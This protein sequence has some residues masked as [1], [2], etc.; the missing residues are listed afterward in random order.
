MTSPEI[1]DDHRER[2]EKLRAELAAA[3]A[4]AYATVETDDVLTYLLDLADAVDDPGRSADPEPPVDPEPPTDPEPPADPEPPFDREAVRDRLAERNRQHADPEDADR[5]DLY[6]I[7]AEFDVAGRSEMT[8]DELLTAVLDRAER[9]AA[10]PFAV[11]GVELSG[12]ANEDGPG[13]DGVDGAA[14]DDEDGA[15]DDDEDGAAGGDTDGDTTGDED[16]A[17]GGDTTGDEDGAADG[18]TDGDTTG[19]EDGAADGDTDGA[20]DDDGGDG[21]DQ[22]DAMM[23]LL[24]THDDKWG[25]ADGDARYEVELPDGT[26]ETARTKDDVRALLFKNY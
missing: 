14:E 1:P 8:K 9:L 23:S 19:D 26:V 24:D 10:N 12:M 3:H 25:E 4:G 15:T 16:G 22:L 20:T 11:V 5:M 18:D 17:A 7:A 6:T 21:A 2:I 13:S